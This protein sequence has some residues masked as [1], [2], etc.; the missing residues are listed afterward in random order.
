MAYDPKLLDTLL[1]GI[2]LLRQFKGDPIVVGIDGYGGAGKSTLAALL[3]TRIPGCQVIPT[4]DFASWED[5]LGWWPRMMREVFSPL[6]EGRVPEYQRYDWIDRVRR[7]WVRVE[8]SVLIIEGVSATRREFRPYLD[9]RVWIE[10]PREVRLA[11]G[12]LRDGP[13]AIQNWLAW[14]EAEDEYV[15]QHRPREGADYVLSTG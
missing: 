5:P 13:E 14:M 1:E 6:A 2:A 9:A 15:L 8:G 3:S 4:D 11:R 12:L 7:D 10:C